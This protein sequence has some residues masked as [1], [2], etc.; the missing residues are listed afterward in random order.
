MVHDVAT[1]TT[2]A[3]LGTVLGAALLV[4]LI[5]RQA[6]RPLE[7]VISTAH[8]IGD[9]SLH[10]RVPVPST[11]PDVVRLSEAVNVMLD[12]LEDAFARRERTEAQ[13]RDLLGAAGFRL[14]RVVPTRMD[15]DVIEA[16]PV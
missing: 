13:Y 12:R 9:T 5:S 1:V 4:W 3:C 14:T 15:V 8:D 16:V 7:D 6:L 11:A 2:V 10:T